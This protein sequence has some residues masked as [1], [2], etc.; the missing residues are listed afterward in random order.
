LKKHSKKSERFVH[1]LI[2][3]SSVLISKNNQKNLKNTRQ[4]FWE[5]RVL[6]GEVV[7][8]RKNANFYIQ[9]GI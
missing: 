2:Q 8:E 9:I 6:C 3:Q 4:P 1:F 7:F 5:P